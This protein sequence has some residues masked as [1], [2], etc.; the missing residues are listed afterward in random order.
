MKVRK[1]IIALALLVALAGAVGW[2][3]G[4][5]GGLRFLAARA[6]PLLPVTLDPAEIDGRLVGPIALGRLEI[7][8]PGLKGEIARVHLD[9]RPV[10]LLRGTLHILEL[11]I[12][13][14]RMEFV[15]LEPT[16]DGARGERE[17]FSLPFAVMLERLALTGG[18]LRSGG[19]VVVEDLDLE[20]AAEASGRALVLRR[21]ELQSSR[22][23]LAGH[24]Q[25][26]L[27][28]AEAWDIDLRWQ[29][30]LD[31]TG[32][33]GHTRV[34][35]APAELEI[36]QEISAPLVARIDG[37]VR[38]L[39][40]A[41]SWAL[42]LAIESLPSSVA[43][44]PEA[45]DGLAA[46]LRIEGDIEANE[47]AGSFELPAY[48]AGTTEIEAQGGWAKSIA[49]VERLELEL[50]DGATLRGSGW[51]E[52]GGAPEAEFMLSGTGLGWPLDGAEREIDL[53]QVELRGTGTGEQWDL[54]ASARAR[55]D[56]LPELA[57]ESVLQWAGSVLTL[58]HV[59]L[60]S[61]DN[62]IH[63]SASGALD[64][65]DDRLEYRL[66]ATGEAR[67]PDFPPVSLE[68]TAAGDAQHVRVETVAAELLGGTVSGAGRVAWAGDQAADF[69]LEF[70][71]LDPSAILPDWPGR[72]A[73][74]LE[75]SGLPAAA[76]GLEIT[77]RS[78][79][80]ELRSLP[81]SG[82]ARLNV[83]GGDYLLRDARIAVGAAVL[84]ASGRLDDA[85]ISLAAT[86]DVP[87]LKS[88]DPG[89]RGKLNASASIAGAR[90][91]PRVELKADGERLRWQAN[92]ARALHID[93]LVDLSG[94]LESEVLAELTDF[95][96]APGPGSSLRLEAAGVPGDHRARL[97][98]Q[99]P[100]LKQS[101]LLA[102]EGG[103]A[104]QR[105]SGRLTELILTDAEQPA[106][107]LQA[108]A[109][110]SADPDS[111]SLERACMDGAFGLLCIGGDWH[112]TGPWRGSAVLS[113]LDL[114]PLSQRFGRGLLATGV[115]TGEVELEADDERFTRLSGGLELTAGELRTAG[116]EDK[117]LL[118]WVRGSLRLTG[119]EETALAELSLKLEGA[120]Y[121]DGRMA[122]GWNAP[123]PPLDG[124]IEAELTQLHLLPTLVPELAELEGKAG[125]VAVIAG[126]VGAPSLEARFELQDGSVDM[127]T[128][129][130]QPDDLQFL[131]T[132]SEGTLSFS[133][134]GRSGE[135]R[136][137][138][139]GRF[140]L[141][142]DGVE[143][144]ATLSGEKILLANL[145]EAQMAASPDLRLHF[146]G[147]DITIGGEVVIPFARITELGG[148]TA[149]SA[150]PDEVLV[151]ARAPA[152]EEGVRVSSRVRV[153][154]G[155]D[156]QIQAAG[157]RGSVEG[158]M[159]TVIQPETLPWGRGEL[160]VVDG[161]F[162]AFGQ[163]LEI[164]T[165][166]LIYT[167]GPLENPGL[168]IRA[169]RRIDQVTA[170]ALV[171]GT[172]KQPEISV[173]SDPPMPR[174]EALSYL[175][176]GRSLS[177]LQSSEQRTVNQAANSLALSGGN[178]IAQDLGRRLGFDEVA[179][180]A[181]NGGEG[182]SLVVSRYIG[183]G[184]YVGYGLGLFD[185]VNTLRLR[186]QI[187]QRLSL[188]AV[189]GEEQAGDLFYTFE[190]D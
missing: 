155:P 179:V 68:L 126:T 92:R 65:G 25:L 69:Q 97:E 127:P 8:T 190:R 48:L 161:T 79:R 164:Q 86:L 59:E 160:R 165:G 50:Q 54:V 39:P 17:P 45:L 152:E 122:V 117:S 51:F 134:T 166:R 87:D 178:L 53:P 84:Q 20:L 81:V 185:T 131:A 43:L 30:A 156:V 55:R 90:A 175:T 60:R 62:A 184:V 3:A 141:T 153:T 46:R 16:G 66:T 154:V 1:R 173:Y 107:S 163:R 88:L 101:L 71:E 111:V 167:G 83:G 137:E 85:V 124:R 19:E 28:P 159:L 106:W 132:L 170:G 96:T 123:D 118:S 180:K 75:L 70:A 189:S 15:K 146:S 22:G 135:G 102:L 130:L 149:I 187:N 103:L 47:V 172:L 9:W 23:R 34:Q 98:F 63:A 147:R 116:E 29:L 115:L 7:A 10:A 157:L 38:G 169:V 140:D 32:I 93:V 58:E 73:G 100:Y 112:R 145:A 78:L 76:D 11:S 12:V 18:A 95:A 158:S 121:V 31:G 151:G 33:A 40:E 181:D 27:D 49:R 110:L 105:W 174:A 13:E 24:A 74:S 21:L 182:A 171:R 5:T 176:L 37:I 143:G 72:L 44:W 150:S 114:E 177:E 89:A 57:L 2:L 162:S 138:T 41:P 64:T 77:L 120:D 14:P 26:S 67:L 104:G 129:G 56:G 168:E 99:R 82:E 6:L 144:R 4:T 52:P 94:A 136:F 148:P 139:E 183:G 35:G 133:A 108:P 188:E 113:Q 42:N 91:A 128:L 142:A 186:F 125:M 80:G 119:D 61:E 109:E 36:A